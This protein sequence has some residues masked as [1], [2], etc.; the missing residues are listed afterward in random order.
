SGTWRPIVG[1]TS[2]KLKVPVTTGTHKSRYRAVFTNTSGKV[3]TDAAKLTVKRS[4]P[5]FTKQPRSVRAKLGTKVRLEVAV[6]G[7]PA[8]KVTWQERAKGGKWRT[9]KGAKGTSLTVK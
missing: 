6:S 4:K 2:T 3:K 9:I 5:R 7:F 1:A 8:P